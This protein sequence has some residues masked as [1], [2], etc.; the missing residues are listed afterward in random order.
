MTRSINSFLTFS[1]LIGLLAVNFGCRTAE[2]V[3]EEPE[4]VYEEPDELDDEMDW[5][6]D[7]EEEVEE[8]DFIEELNSINFD[9]DMSDITN[10]ASRQLAENIT[11][12]RDNPNVNIRVDAFTD[13]IGGDQ[14]NVRLSVRRA[15]S[16]AN[17]YR[18]NGVSSNRIE[19]RGLGKHPVPCSETEANDGT[20]GCAKNRVAE[21]HPLNPNQ[22]SRN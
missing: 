17:F 15:E 13:H 6:N 10:Q 11:L 8:A 3:V 5:M 19:T 14:Y 12:L 20:Q 16:V 21:S 18:T 2:E 4:E 1:L 9:F 22:F 7:E